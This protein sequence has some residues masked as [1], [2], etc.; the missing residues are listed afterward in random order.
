MGRNRA[1]HVA[2]RVEGSFWRFV[3]LDLLSSWSFWLDG[4]SGTGDGS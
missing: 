4:G 2:Y 3:L 1:V